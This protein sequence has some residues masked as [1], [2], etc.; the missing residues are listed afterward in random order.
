MNDSLKNITPSNAAN[1][2]KSEE[3]RNSNPAI[4]TSSSLNSSLIEDSKSKGS[5]LSDSSLNSSSIENSKSKGSSLSDSSANSSSISSSDSP[6]SEKQIAFEKELELFLQDWKSEKP[7]LWVKT[8][9]STGTPKPLE[10]EKE[11][12]KAS[13]RMTCDFL[14][15]KSGDSALLCMPLAYIAGKMVVVRAQERNLRLIAVAPTGHPFAQ[16]N[17]APTFAAL[18]PLQVFNSLQVP[19]EKECMKQV[20]HLIIGGGAVDA[21]MAKQ[22]KDFPNAVWSTY[23]MTET[24][25]HIALRRL[26]GKEASDAYTPLPGVSVSLSDANTLR[27]SAP[28]VYRETLVTNDVAE[29]ESDGNFRIKGRRDNTVNSG[30]IK[31]QIEEVEARLKEVLNRPFQITARLDAKFGEILILLYEG[32]E[33]PAGTGKAEVAEEAL[34]KLCEENLP[35][36]WIPKRYKKIPALPVTE[37][38]K[39]DRATARKLAAED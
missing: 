13:A 36:Y 19:E 10:V 15:L 5:S 4:Q 3:E 22:L 26:N 25:S 6:K 32:E 39:P 33:K 1:S 29:M 30:G 11:R 24:L 35:L 12:M 18:I 28:H 2:P 21:A 37:T 20:K 17:E 16:L 23:G 8:S 34:R 38:G 14:G 27:I 7:T 31:I 9:G